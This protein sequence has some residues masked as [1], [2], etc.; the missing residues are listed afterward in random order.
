MPTS[1]RDVFLSL[2]HI[3]IVR[4]SA[5]SLMEALVKKVCASLLVDEHFK[6]V[7]SAEPECLLDVLVVLERERENPNNS[8]T[9]TIF[10]SNI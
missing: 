2:I 5:Y 9:K 8:R 6:L 3:N 1:R 10:V 7:L 4:R